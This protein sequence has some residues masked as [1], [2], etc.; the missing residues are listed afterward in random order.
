[1]PRL[2]DIKEQSLGAW[3]L[4]SSISC[5]DWDEMS[6]SHCLIIWTY[7]IISYV[8]VQ[9]LSHIW[10]YFTPWTA[11]L[12][13]SLSFTIS[14]SFLKLMSI[15]S[16]MPSNH[17]VLCHPFLLLPSFFPSM[18]VF[19]N[20]STLCIRWPK[21]WSLSFSINPSNEYSGFISFRI[22]YFDLLAVQG[23]LRS[24]LQHHS[25]KASILHFSASFIIQISHL[26]M[27]T[28]KTIALGPDAMILVLWMLSFNCHTFTHY[29]KKFY[30]SFLKKITLEYSAHWFVLP[31]YPPV[32]L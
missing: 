10:F 9:L 2:W 1:M 32:A 7:K 29:F 13:S 25:S 17:L 18:R 3:P 31:C 30:N 27:T 4:C 8:V 15:E 20:G 5:M 19:S 16:S 23:A 11:A 26:Y 28:G 22:D 6:F 12:Q 14:W 24:L 21:Y